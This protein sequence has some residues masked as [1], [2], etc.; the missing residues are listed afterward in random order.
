MIEAIETTADVLPIAM[1]LSAA[2][3]FV[4]GDGF[5][6]AVRHRQCLQQ[7]NEDLRDELDR[8]R[9]GEEQLHR[10]IQEQRGVINDIHRNVVALSKNLNHP[11]AK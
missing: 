9:A 1:L 11:A 6:D 8:A 4:I 10:T 2:F 7:A 3:G 5:G